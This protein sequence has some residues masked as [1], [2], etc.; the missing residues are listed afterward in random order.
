[1]PW[2]S[3]IGGPTKRLKGCLTDADHRSEAPGTFRGNVT[4]DT[5]AP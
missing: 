3:G 2:L 5:A 1:M 4:D